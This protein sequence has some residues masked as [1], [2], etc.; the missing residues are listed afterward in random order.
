[1]VNAPIWKDTVYT[2]ST[3]GLSYYIQTDS[4]T[5]FNG[6]AFAKPNSNYIVININKI[7]QNYLDNSLSDFRSYS[8]TTLS[9]SSAYREFKLYSTN[10][11][12]LETYWFLYDWSYLDEAVFNG[13]YSMSRPINNHFADG[14]YQFNT[15]LS[16]GSVTNHLERVNGSYC[17]EYAMYYLNAYGGWDSYLFE[18]K[19]RKYDNFTQYEYNRSFNNNTIE[20]EKNRYISEVEETYELGTGLMEDEE[21]ENFSFNLVGTNQAYLHNLKTD[22]IFPVMVDEA[23]IE[24]KKYSNDRKMIEYIIRVKSSQNRIRR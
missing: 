23:T 12:L 20:F 3:T 7:V 5:I 19:C 14:M 24:Y 2:A 13:T 9:A 17:G 22:E 15:V 4:E 21:A 18:G 16:S 6:R 1:M 8:A 10:G 11:T